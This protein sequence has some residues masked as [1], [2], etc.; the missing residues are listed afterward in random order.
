MWKVV[1]GKLIHKTDSSRVRFKTYINRD[2]LNELTEISENE[3]THISY[4]LENGLGNLLKDKNFYFNKK[5]RLKNKVEFRTT[6]DKEILEKAK[7]L[8]KTHKLNFTDIIQ[9]SV[10]YIKLEEVKKKSWKHRIE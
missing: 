3:N 4:L 6:C 9:S 7:E 8:S 2:L 10:K 5:D 1:N